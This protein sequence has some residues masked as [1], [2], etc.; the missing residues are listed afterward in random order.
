MRLQLGIRVALL[1]CGLVG[2]AVLAACTT[3]GA[4]ASS[5]HIVPTT[6]VPAIAGL[7]APGSTAAAAPSDPIDSAA[8]T[9]T[10]DQIQADLSSVD[11]NLSQVSADLSTAQ[12]DS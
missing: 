6:T 10:F 7:P 11:S 8:A 4:P 9:Q 3:T 12:G 1:V 2:T 5:H